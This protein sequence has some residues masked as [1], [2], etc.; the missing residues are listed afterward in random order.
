MA[1][2]KVSQFDLEWW[3]IQK[4]AIYLMVA[5]LIL[6]LIAGGVAL[7][8]W[9][10]GNPLKSVAV[11]PE[12]LSGARFMAFEGDVRVIRAST[13]QV[14]LAN[15]DVQLYAGDTVQTQADGR[16]RISMADGSTVVVR[17]NSTIIIRDNESAEDGKKSSVHVVVDSGQ[18]LVR[19][20]DQSENNQ[21]VIETPKT[22][23]QIGSQ[24]AASFGVTQDGTEEIRVNSGAVEASNRLGERLSLQGGQYVSVNQSGTI[25]KPQ[26]LL[27]V[28]LPF[29][30]RDL[31][32]VSAAPNGSATVPLRW[33]KPQ[34]GVAAFYRVEVATSPFFVPEGKVIERDQLSATQ[35]SASDLRPGSYFWRIRAT[36]STGQTS[37]WSEPLKFIVTAPGVKSAALPASNLSAILLGGNV[38]IIRG[39]TQPGA[40]VRVFD[41]E[42][43]AA[44]D[45][46]FQVQISPPAN[47]RDVTIQISD[48]QGNLSTYK[49]PLN[50]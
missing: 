37:E 39:T 50:R 4:R 8:V 49:V 34:S 29:Q 11:K 44:L 31:E 27:D 24:T 42:A 5:G 33:Q 32:K 48:T 6:C 21:N 23:N 45:G 17:P 12:A 9:K 46:N 14:V 10:Y 7:Y 25:S 38:Y 35:F 43:S 22:Q 18:M 41:R 36:A 1:S 20:S 3:V 15:Q 26:R 19:T 28:P 47:T 40:N 16:A 13:R 30:P 2:T